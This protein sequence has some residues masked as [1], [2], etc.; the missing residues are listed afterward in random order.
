[1]P[2]YGASDPLPERT[3][4]IE[5][6]ADNVAVFMDAVGIDVAGIHGFHTGASVATAFA[7]RHPTRVSV[8][9]VVGLLCLTPQERSEWLREYAPPFEPR[10]DGGHLAWVWSRL[11]DQSVFF[12]WFARTAAARVGM[13]AL[14]PAAVQASLPDWLRSGARYGAAYEAAFRYGP[15][16]DLP[17]IRTPHVVLDFP[18]DPLFPHLD[19]LPVSSG[20]VEIVR[21][22]A[23]ADAQAFA[24]QVLQRHPGSPAD[25]I[26]PPARGHGGATWQHYVSVAGMQLRVLRAG[27]SDTRPVVLLHGAQSSASAFAGLIGALGRQRPAVA[28]EL[29]GHGESDAAPDPEAY[30]V[31]ALAAVLAAALDALG[32]EALDLIGVEAGAA[33]A[34]AVALAASGSLRVGHLLLASAIDISLDPRMQQGLIASYPPPPPP[35]SHG[36]HLLRAWHEARDHLL[37]FPW[38]DRRRACAAPA[39]PSLDPRFIQRSVT[40]AILAGAAGTALRQA[41]LG[42]PLLAQLSLLARL[43]RVNPASSFAASFAAPRCHPRFGHTQ[44]LA[45]EAGCDFLE[46]PSDTADWCRIDWCRVTRGR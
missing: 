36:G 10:W 21:C 41:E 31:E 20:N 18:T 17:S 42:Y 6:L 38:Y 39:D 40:D 43:S 46:L 3:L 2:G 33:V 24:C 12:P 15:E 11:R 19:R 35:D 30:R 28:I 1:M 37:F 4:T 9:V 16:A 5:I 23:P 22:A 25:F 29:P 34:V 32:M 7:R 26:V 14:A 8:A 27:A 13:D 44:R 45:G